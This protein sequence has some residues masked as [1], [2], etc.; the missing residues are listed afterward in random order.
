MFLA[1]TVKWTLVMFT[2]FSYF[3]SHA[4]NSASFSWTV[5]IDF[6]FKFFKIELLIMNKKL[7]K[8]L[9]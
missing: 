1:T 9:S 2:C 6:G 7:K 5:R 8:L 3:G 4:D